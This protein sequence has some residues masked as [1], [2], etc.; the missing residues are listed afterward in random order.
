MNGAHALIRTLVANGVDVVLHEPGHVG[1]AVRRRARR[2]SRDARRPRAVRRRRDRRGRRVRPHGRQARG[3]AAAP[4]PRSRQRPREPA[5][6]APGPH[7]DRQHRRR[8]G[9]VPPGVRRA[10]HLRHR[11]ARAQ[12]VGLDPRHDAAA[13]RSRATRPTRCCG[14]AAA[15]ADRD[16][17]SCPADTT[18]LEAGEPAAPRRRRARRDVPRRRDRRRRQGVAFRRTGRVAARRRGASASVGC[19]PRAGSRRHRREAARRD[20]PGPARARRGAAARSNGSA[21]SP[22]SRSRSST[23]CATSCSSTPRRR[24]RSSRIPEKP[25]VLVPDGCEV[26]TLALG[27][28]RC[29]A[30][31]GA[32]RR[33][34]SARKPAGAPRAARA[35]GPTVPTGALSA[36]VGRAR[37]SARCCPKAR[38]SST[39]RRPAGCSCRARPRVRPRHDWLTLTGGAIGLGHAARDRRRGRVPRS[40]GHLNLEADGSAM[41]TL[42]VAVDAGARRARRHDDH[43][44]QPFVR[45]PQHRARAAS[46]PAPAARGAVA[47]RPLAPAARLRRARARAWASTRPGRRPPRSSLPRCERALAEPGPASHRRPACRPGL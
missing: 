8:P 32:T 16:A 44:R 37:R 23:A 24:C 7:A 47:V 40:Q 11:R 10:A 18:W 21:I 14:T 36:Q 41:Y 34:A 15:R 39:R 45:D 30:R 5:Q 1:D 42:Q 3:D 4:R 6:R 27:G 17:R 20:V 46:A 9:D 28:R 13:R 38:S 33:R 2:R 35:S 29:R 26:H 22:S 43:L 19:S 31:A 12:R 25:S